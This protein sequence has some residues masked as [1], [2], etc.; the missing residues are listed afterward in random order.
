MNM[1]RRK[2]TKINNLVSV[3]IPTYNR[4]KYLLNAIKSVKEQTYKDI[5]IIVVN[6][7]STQEEYYN[8]D[9]KEKFGD[10]FFIVHL[11]RNSQSYL[12]KI[13]GGGNSRNIGIMLSKGSYIAFL[14]DDDYFMPDK[15]EKQIEAM[16]KTKSS[17]SCTEGYFG[18]GSYQKDKKYEVFHYLGHHWEELIKIFTHH[19]K[20]ELLFKM[21]EN[22]INIWKEEELKYHNCTCGGSSMIIRKDLLEKTGNFIISNYAEDWDYWKRAIKYGQC[23]FLREPLT[24]IDSGHG[25]G[26]LY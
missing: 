17:M 15:I 24:Y 23:V 21:Y 9:W 18:Y 3:V 22:N 19:G 13:C 12:G 20:R 16:K 14:D 8:Y 25:D 6:D 2:V 26:Q 1:N 10:N 5:E 11:P 4:F 7:Y